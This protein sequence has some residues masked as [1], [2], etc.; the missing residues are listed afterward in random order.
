MFCNVK[1]LRLQSAVN[2]SR[3]SEK[4]S[5][6]RRR[7]RRRRR[8]VCLRCS[9]HH[10]CRS[11]DVELPGVM[12][13]HLWP[14]KDSE[15][16]MLL[17][18]LLKLKPP[19]P[20]LPP[21]EPPWGDTPDVSDEQMWR[22]KRLRP[23]SRKCFVSLSLCALHFV[24]LLP[25]RQLPSPLKNTPT[26]WKS[27][28]FRRFPSLLP[29][30]PPPFSSRKIPPRRLSWFAMKYGGGVSLWSSVSAAGSR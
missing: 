11:W 22:L 15:E 28:Y 10:T 7:R 3:V 8:R 13:I 4:V 27:S 12:I 9:P 25:W 19:L 21:A 29:S 24:W 23:S 18:S 2:G 1:T 20:P 14:L 26:T 5:L 6:Q 16:L 30:S 17:H